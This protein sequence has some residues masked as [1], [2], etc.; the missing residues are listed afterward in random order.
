M[1]TELGKKFSLIIYDA[2]ISVLIMTQIQPS[3]KQN[4][5]TMVIIL[6]VEGKGCVAVGGVPSLSNLL[7]ISP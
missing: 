2:A 3:V 5:A 7:A 6:G 1:Q 4:L